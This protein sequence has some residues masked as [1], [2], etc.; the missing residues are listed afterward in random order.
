[1]MSHPSVETIIPTDDDYNIISIVLLVE[2]IVAI[3]VMIAFIL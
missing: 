3:G 2:I 1:M